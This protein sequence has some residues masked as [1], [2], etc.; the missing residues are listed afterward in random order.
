[1]GAG[2]TTMMLLTVLLASPEPLSIPDGSWL[3]PDYRMVE[4]WTL[5]PFEYIQGELTNLGHIG[6]SS[7]TGD[8]NIVLV[9][10]GTFSFFL[11]NEFL[12]RVPVVMSSNPKL[13]YSQNGEY[14][15]VFSTLNTVQLSRISRS[16]RD[17]VALT[18]LTDE[19]TSQPFVVSVS[20]TGSAVILFN[21]DYYFFN[22]DLTL[23][24][25]SRS[26]GSA[27]KCTMSSDGEYVFL[28]RGLNLNAYD[29]SGRELWSTPLEETPPVLYVQR[30]VCSGDGSLVCVALQKSFFVYNTSDGSLLFEA[31]HDD[32]TANPILSESGRFLA[33]ETMY[34]LADFGETSYENIVTIDLSP[35]QFGEIV[36]SRYEFE[37]M[38]NCSIRM[39]P[40]SVSDTG[41]VLATLYSSSTSV[42]NRLILLDENASP[43]WISDNILA[44]NGF[45]YTSGYYGGLSADG[46]YL[47]VYHD[48]VVTGLRIEK[49]GLPTEN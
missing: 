30:L 3:S 28:T 46:S 24:G 12:G 29:N 21:M 44:Q 37:E 27:P 31:H 48:N 36:E 10:D 45:D 11:N 33:F 17:Y 42:T 34:G 20:N 13:A 49:V 8:W 38:I 1:M 25:I 19:E 15:V 4:E 7:S 23:A 14:T 6:E 32:F 2:Q 35:E 43:I 39:Y 26:H 18:D 5:D 22:P 9:D 41:S 40:I 16:M 47:W